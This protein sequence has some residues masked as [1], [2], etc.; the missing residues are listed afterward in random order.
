MNPEQY[1]AIFGGWSR[2]SIALQKDAKII[3]NAK[4]MIL[5]SEEK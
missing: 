5:F 1:Q 3:L 2:E 4:K